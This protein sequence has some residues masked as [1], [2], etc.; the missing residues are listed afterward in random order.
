MRFFLSEHVSK[1]N[2]EAQIIDLQLN[3]LV[4]TFEKYPPPQCACLPKI[5]MVPE[6]EESLSV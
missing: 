6:E 1:N 3:S 4:G 5:L 2:L